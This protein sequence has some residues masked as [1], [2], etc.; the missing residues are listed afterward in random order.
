MIKRKVGSPD[1]VL[2]AHIIKDLQDEI[3]ALRDE[4]RL[5]DSRLVGVTQPEI[6]S[7][8]GERA[9]R[10]GV[11]PR[12]EFAIPNNTIKL[13]AYV[14]KKSEWDAGGA[15]RDIWKG[16][17]W[18]S[19]ITD[20][21]REAESFEG[22][23]GKPLDFDTTYYVVF[24]EA[25]N[26]GEGE[27]PFST[28]PED[29]ITVQ[30][31]DGTP[32]SGTHL[33]E[34]TTKEVFPAIPDRPDAADIIVNRPYL[35]DGINGNAEVHFRLW[36]S[37]DH[38]QYVEDMDILR[39][40]VF[41]TPFVRDNA[42]GNYVIAPDAKVKRVDTDVEFETAIEQ[43]ITSKHKAIKVIAILPLGVKYRWHKSMLV[44]PAGKGKGEPNAGTGG[45]PFVDFW[46]GGKIAET[47][48]E[49]PEPII[50]VKEQLDSRHTD[51]QLSA[52]QTTTPV[53]LKKYFIEISYD[54]NGS[55][56]TWK[57]VS[58]N[59]LRDEENFDTTISGSVNTNGT[60]VTW[61]SGTK[62]KNDGSWAAGTP[63]TINGVT[64]RIASV[65]SDTSLTLESTAGVQNGVAYL[66]AH[67]NTHT[68]KHKKRRQDSDTFYLRARLI[69]VGSI[70]TDALKH[71]PKKTTTV[72]NYTEFKP[73][74]GP[75][76]GVAAMPDAADISTVD[77]LETAEPDAKIT[78]TIKC[79]VP[80]GSFNP[81]GTPMT[82]KDAY[83]TEAYA[84]LRD[85]DGSEK[86]RI[87][88]DIPDPT[89]TEV[90]FTRVVPKRGEVLAWTKS[91][92]LNGDG[93]RITVD[94]TPPTIIAGG[95][96]RATANGDVPV[97]SINSGAVTTKG[98]KNIFLP[99]EFTQTTPATALKKLILEEQV[100]GGNWTVE[101]DYSIKNAK[102]GTLDFHI[103][104]QAYTVAAG[105]AIILH[106]KHPANSAV[107]YRAKLV[108]LGGFVQTSAEYSLTSDV[109]TANNATPGAL[110]IPSVVT[111]QIDGDPEKG[112][113]RIALTV[114]T[115]NTQSFND[116][117][118][119][120]ITFVIQRRNLA[121]DADIGSPIKETFTVP[122]ADASNS[123]LTHEFFI[124]QGEK[125]RI[126]SV[127]AV[128]GD[129]RTQTDGSVD[130]TAGGLIRVDPGDAK[131][132]PSPSFGTIAR[133]DGS[134]KLDRVPVTLTQ[135]GS[136]I[137]WF[138]RIVLEVSINGGAWDIEKDVGL[139]Q[140]DTL[141]ASVSASVTFNWTVKRKAGVSAQYRVLAY[142]VG[143][144]AS[145]NPAGTHVVSSSQSATTS[146][147]LTDTAIPGAPP[148][149][150]IRYK[151][152]HFMIETPLP[153]SNINTLRK[154]EVTVRVDDSIGTIL[155][156]LDK[157]GNDWVRSASQVW[158]NAGLSGNYHINLSKSQLLALTNFS[159]A[160]TIVVATRAS[161]DLTVSTYNESSLAS[162][163]LSSVKGHI[164]TREVVNAL[165]VGMTM[166]APQNFIKNGE[167]GYG[168]STDLKDFLRRSSTT[169]STSNVINTT[170]TNNAHWDKTNHRIV[171]NE[172]ADRITQ[173]M[174]K[175]FVPG[176]FLTFG[177]LVKSNG[178]PTVAIKCLLRDNDGNN[179]TADENDNT[180][181][182][183]SFSIQLSSTY[184]FIG[185]RVRIKTTYDSTKKLHVSFETSS[186]ISS[187]N[188]IIIDHVGGYRGKQIFTWSPKPG[189]LNNAG[190]DED[191]D[192]DP[193]STGV[194]PDLGDPSGTQGGGPGYGAGGI[195]TPL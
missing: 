48:D 132:V 55:T 22:E 120:Q 172:E 52:I 95:I 24:L 170:T 42:T 84:I 153:T 59:S 152:D 113:A 188:Q 73:Q 85:P 116:N 176:D 32:G 125:Y 190:N 138:K 46:A 5:D 38:T 123:S 44:N 161:N 184:Q 50:V 60:A 34:W 37:E 58:K 164:N 144:K 127:I 29:E 122:T 101:K 25:Y 100:D 124:R 163:S 31:G 146:D 119:T 185:W 92:L 130:F 76:K 28:N 81:T 77:N 171:W 157:S 78:V 135:D 114:T 110:N 49:I 62:F 94:S 27:E 72:A 111:N 87:G 159:T 151:N 141:H 23:F 103:A 97:P 162:R 21:D 17:S 108:A 6:I 193:A 155:G 3:D 56:G 47:D 186:N 106:A 20:D 174:G 136:D 142:A 158:L 115:F 89:Q 140:N 180:V 35:E 109:D 26:D 167:C 154:L 54:W 70:G 40:V 74:A 143:G 4:V 2:E 39:G 30:P 187:S 69:G 177:M 107:K 45:D 83:V 64:Y 53:L 16:F 91:I 169:W 168:S 18:R 178:T 149:P 175:K 65:A 133:V 9:D 13:R 51:V 15:K 90:T 86:Y 102:D 145:G 166:A 96:R 195:V 66:G 68:I 117:K 80:D 139:K 43:D 19:E 61:V 12:F 63:I 10:K 7:L 192:V 156:Y 8:L 82:F 98:N 173:S 67:T 121:N 57:V 148:T 112:L 183:N 194:T 99:V 191:F 181:T 105:R 129:R 137:V 118:I 160:A 14:A 93:S 179:V 88:G 1:V 104:G 189:E 75:P 182:D 131:I 36:V 128:N 147:L 126:K 71:S 150:V 134:N 11:Y 41:L 33:F 165:D 79:R